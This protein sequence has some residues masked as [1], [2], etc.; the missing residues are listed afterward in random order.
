MRNTLLLSLLL[1]PLL[2]V[3]QR[4]DWMRDLPDE[5]YL[6]EVSI[7]GSHDSG[8]ASEFESIF[9][10]AFSQTQTLS[11]DEQLER[12]VRAIDLR[13]RV[14]SGELR[15]AHGIAT[16]K[17]TMAN[18]LKSVVD[19]LNAHPTEFV[20]AHLLYATE[21]DSEQNDYNTLLT[22]LLTSETIKPHL[23]KFA[24]ALTVADMRGKLLLLSR[25]DMKACTGYT[26]GVFSGW[27]GDS[28]DWFT[29][30]HASIENRYRD[31]STLSKA[32]AA[33]QD[34]STYSSGKA[35]TK[36][37]AALRLADFMQQHR[38]Y[39]S[40]V[41]QTFSLNFL[42][43]Y[44][45]SL[46]LSTGYADNA[47]I[48]NKA[49]ADHLSDH[50]GPVGIIMMDYAAVDDAQPVSKAATMGLE[51]V[52]A[53]I[54][55][56]FRYLPLSHARTAP[57]GFEEVT[58]LIKNAAFEV[59]AQRWQNTNGF[60]A[61]QM[62]VAEQYNKNFDTYQTITS[63]PAGTYRLV[64]RG[65]YRCGGADE[66]YKSHHDGTEQRLALA[67][68]GD[69]TNTMPLPSIYASPQ[70]A[71][72]ANNGWSG[73]FP[74]TLWEAN[75]DLNAEQ[76]YETDMLEYEQPTTQSLRLGV[77]KTQTI[78][79]DWTTFTDFRLFYRPL[80]D[81]ITA[82]QQDAQAPQ[83]VYTLSGQRLPATAKLPRGLYIQDGHK[84]IR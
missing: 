58:N 37:D 70:A 19:F 61:T 50:T 16:L 29:Q 42:S 79:Y 7:P 35:Q 71:N 40:P 11:I 14:V 65:F 75:V 32:K 54:D 77:M 43:A 26:G 66:A 36:T 74:N 52:N 57:D 72:D 34:I 81:A 27:P 5:A 59:N 38:V 25:N 15:C 30:K 76:Y 21:Y 10:Q 22:T 1:F 49:I 60:T 33:V 56:N 78:A 39:L 18:A 6:S 64:L 41:Q 17:L 23:I 67:Y 20:V 63:A 9:L 53:I 68:L 55:N 31:Y 84:T 82:P 24:P 8:T 3:A 13:P 83:T 46:S 69:K 45:G 80:A 2:A 62:G 47:A 48:Q 12:G 4:T 44:S 28:E 51:A 73:L